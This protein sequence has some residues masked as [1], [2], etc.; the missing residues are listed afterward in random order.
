[1][2]CIRNRENQHGLDSLL[3]YQVDCFSNIV[4]MFYQ[5]TL[6]DPGGALKAPPPSDFLLSRI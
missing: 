1:M 5:L 4:T 2:Y 3:C 6:Y